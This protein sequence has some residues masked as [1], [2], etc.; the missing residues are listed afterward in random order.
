MFAN[1]VHANIGI[2]FTSEHENI[3]STIS[4]NFAVECDWIS[5]NFRNVQNT[6]FL[7]K[8]GLFVEKKIEFFFK[9]DKGGKFAVECVSNGNVSE[10]YLFCP[11]YDVFFCQNFENCESRKSKKNS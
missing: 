4:G 10:K 9:I 7:E 3:L 1:C 6:G 8:I 11:S 5:E 2:L